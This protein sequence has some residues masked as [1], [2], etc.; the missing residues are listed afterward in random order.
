MSKYEELKAIENFE[1]TAKNAKIIKIIKKKN[2]DD[3]ELF[4]KKLPNLNLDVKYV[5]K[6]ILPK[7]NE[8]LKAIGNFE[9]TAKNAKVIKI[10]NR[11]Y[12]DE[13]EFFATAQKLPKF[14]IHLNPKMQIS[15]KVALREIAL[16]REV[17]WE[18]FTKP[19]LLESIRRA[20]GYKTTGVHKF[21]KSELVKHYLSIY[22]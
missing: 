10:V 20:E 13:V 18:K 11:P 19:K 12:D 21:N 1:R 7:L 9:Q 3:I 16:R 4:A 8:E 6:I 2:T 5:K 22:H 14:R 15:H 17:G